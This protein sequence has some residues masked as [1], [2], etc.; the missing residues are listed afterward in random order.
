MDEQK[1]LFTARRWHDNPAEGCTVRDG[2]PTSEEERAKIK[3]RFREILRKEGVL[4]D[5]KENE[6]DE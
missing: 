6:N 3:K 5:D 1:K 4:L 2:E